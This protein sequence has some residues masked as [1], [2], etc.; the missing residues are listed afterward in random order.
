[1]TRLRERL[2]A[3]TRAAHARVDAAFARYALG[4]RAG[5]AAFLQATARALPA[6]E[7]AAEAA[8]AAALLPDWAERRRA[9]ALAEDLERLGAGRPA[10][11]PAPALA[12]EG[13]VWGALYVLEGSR[14][15]ARLLL[16]QARAGG[17]PAVAAAT[18]YLAHGAGRRFWPGF[19]ARLEACAP[20]ET[21]ALA[22]AEAA[23]AAFEAAARG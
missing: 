12:S 14:M 13:A 11:G 4:E 18:A 21:E 9:A 10:P 1:V 22:G 19:V 8:G 3:E 15:G 23:F 7:A 6:V 2:R 5:Y 17:D 20:E 16:A